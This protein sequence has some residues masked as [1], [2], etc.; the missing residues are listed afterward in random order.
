M[1]WKPPTQTGGVS[2]KELIYTISWNKKGEDNIR[3]SQNITGGR[4]EY[5]IPMDNYKN[6]DNFDYSFSVI[7]GAKVGG[8]KTVND[9]FVFK[10]RGMH[11]MSIIIVIF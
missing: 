6:R 3:F 7:N 9:T 4:L 10:P 11:N 5:N 1:K 8:N 2:L